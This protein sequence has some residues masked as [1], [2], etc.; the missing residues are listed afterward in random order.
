MAVYR[1]RVPQ[2]K[3]HYLV[4]FLSGSDWTRLYPA[5]HGEIAIDPATGSV[6]RLTMLT[7]LAAPFQTISEG[8]RVDYGPEDIGGRTYICPVKG[9]AFS[10]LPAE[11][12]SPWNGSGLTPPLQTRLNDVS[13]TNYHL[14]RADVRILGSSE[15][16]PPQ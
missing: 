1:Y 13:F 6:L 15:K 12:A 14:F 8:I 7:D 11:A 2:D 9:V 3:S 10:R 4:G 16:I 5:Y